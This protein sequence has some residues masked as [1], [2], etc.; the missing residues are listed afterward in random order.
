MTD[1]RTSLALTP[2][3]ALP[4]IDVDTATLTENTR[5]LR[6]LCGARGVA[7]VGVTKGL[8]GHP[9]AVRALLDAGLPALADARLANIRRIRAA[10]I[11]A[12]V[13]LLRPPAPGELPEAV[14][15]CDTIFATAPETLAALAHAARTAG[16]EVQVV[17]MADVGDLREG[18]PPAELPAIAARAARLD[19]LRIAG[20]G[21][22]FA[23]HRGLLPS[24]ENL[25]RFMTLV[26]EI[27]TLTG[28]PLE[29]LS[30][31]NSAALPFLQ[32]GALPPRINQFR[33]GESL[34]LG[35]DAAEQRPLPGTRPDA[36]TLAAGILEIWT[37]D[38][39]QTDPRAHIAFGHE[40][41]AL[42]QGTLRLAVLGLG[43]MD[44]DIAGLMPHSVGL[45]ML[46]YSSDHT[47]LD[48]TARPD[49]RVADVLHFGLSYS[50]LARAMNMRDVNVALTNRT[51]AMMRVQ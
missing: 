12:H 34:L 4:R 49:L 50:A 11:D 31:G 5:A 32:S 46:G 15:L 3:R 33:L 43:A 29:I 35:H 2:S 1:P 24:R 13:Q 27:E 10:G 36:F 40:P 26:E 44:T 18:A 38:T 42:P 25:G 45:C 37:R 6:R 22:N 30:A 20:L 21:T 14:R 16:R 41:P 48:I 7:V 28:Q 17:L 19:G 23:C 51:A 47:V 8:A 39:A 9:G